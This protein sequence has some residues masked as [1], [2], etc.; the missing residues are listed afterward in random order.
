MD[1]IIEIFNE[2]Q[3]DG[4]LWKGKRIWKHAITPDDQ[5]AAIDELTAMFMC[6]SH[7]IKRDAYI[8]N[9]AKAINN[10]LTDINDELKRLEKKMQA[11]RKQADKLEKQEDAEALAKARLEEKELE[12]SIILLRNNRPH[13]LDEKA[14]R[15]SISETIRRAKN[16]KEH[17]KMQAELE[18][19]IRSAEDAGLPEDFEG[20]MADVYAALQYGIFIHKGVYYSR[21]GKGGGDYAISNFTM[22][23]I[24]HIPTNDETS[25]RLIAVKNVFGH[26]VVININTDDFVSAGSF[27]KIISRRG[28]FV[29]KGADSDLCRLQEYLQKDETS[30]QH[31]SVLG[32][33]KTYKFWAWANG[34]TVVNNDNTAE[35][36]PVDNHGIVDYNGK[37]YFL[38]AYSQLMREKDGMMVNE[39]KFVYCQPVPGFGFNE[40]ATVMYKTYGKKSIAAILWYIATVYRDIVMKKTRRMPLLNLFG[41]PGAGKGELYD[42]LMHLFGFKQDQVMLGGASTAVGFMRKFAQFNNA[43]VGLDEYKNNLPTKIIESLKNL[44]DGIGY[45]RGKMS[46]DFATESTPV[47]SS[48]ILL[49]Q[50]MPTIE[51]ALFMRCIMLAFQEGKFTEEQRTNYKRLKD[52]IEPNG[53]SYITA[54]LL[55]FRHLFEESFKDNQSLIFKQTIKDTNNVEVDDR[56]IQNIS[57]LLTCMHLIQPHVQFPFTYKEAK[58]WLIDNMLQQH[59]ILAGNNDV[60]KFWQVVE[61]LFYRGDIVENRDFKLQDGYCYIRLQ[62][63]HPMYQMEMINRRDMN[64]LSLPTLRHYLQLDKNIFCEDIKVRFADGSNTMTY[65]MKYNKL[66]IDLIRIKKEAFETPEQFNLR[67]KTK[68]TEMGIDNGGDEDTASDEVPFPITKN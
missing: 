42:S 23:I 51:P 32:W 49:G 29:F 67:A 17:K 34:L 2:L 24:Y 6:I 61:A 4:V 7:E 3:Q 37:R 16:E 45:E 55:R 31:I 40:W 39:K 33:H 26:E 10:E 28:N 46:Q 15:K 65:K 36:I 60:A 68:Y 14:L 11:L 20:T 12:A 38:P 22:Q 25:Y 13:Q 62:Q 41:P 63:V 44:Y 5:A 35:F 8:S 18:K 64:Y 50:E 48:C 66:G 53:L 57:V 27:K 54:D 47:S 58:G 1:S 59:T 30:A 21:G 52:E 9:L 19:Q 43:M 56:M